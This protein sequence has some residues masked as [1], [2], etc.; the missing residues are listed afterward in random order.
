MTNHLLKDGFLLVFCNINH[1]AGLVRTFLISL[2]HR[3]TKKILTS[4]SLKYQL[5]HNAKL[6]Y[7]K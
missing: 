3:Q 2:N 7:V 5:Y 4:S 1:S 6:D